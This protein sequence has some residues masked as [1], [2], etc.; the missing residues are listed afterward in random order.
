MGVKTEMSSGKHGRVVTSRPRNPFAN[1]RVL[2]PS[3]YV[4][5]HSSRTTAEIDRAIRRLKA[6]RNKRR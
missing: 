2:N 1:V 6:T 3:A 5:K 4:L